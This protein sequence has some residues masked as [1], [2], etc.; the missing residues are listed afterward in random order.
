MVPLP[1]QVHNTLNCRLGHD[2]DDRPFLDLASFDGL[3]TLLLFPDKTNKCEFPACL[4]YHYVNNG[5]ITAHSD[6]SVIA[7]EY[8]LPLNLRAPSSFLQQ[9]RFS[10]TLFCIWTITQTFEHCHIFE[11]THCLC[12]I[13]KYV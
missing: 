12:D 4:I 2:L 8:V 1:A 6:G 10:P 11:L 13:S 7:M 5:C 3:K 9:P